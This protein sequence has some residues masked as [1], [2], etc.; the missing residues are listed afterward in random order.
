MTLYIRNLSP[1][2][3]ADDLSLLFHQFGKVR[4]VHL[5]ANGAYHAAFVTMN[6]RD[7][8]DSARHF[9]NGKDLKGQPLEI[10]NAPEFRHSAN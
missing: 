4:R 8:A 6:S 3:T 9:L 1:S 2:A 10:V 7:E 5:A